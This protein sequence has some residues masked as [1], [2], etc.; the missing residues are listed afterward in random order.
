VGFA[1]RAAIGLLSLIFVS[2][3]LIAGHLIARVERRHSR[4][5][6]QAGLPS[7]DFLAC[8]MPDC[9]M[10]SCPPPSRRLIDVTTSPTAAP[11]RLADAGDPS[12]EAQAPRP[13]PLPA[14]TNA[15][16]LRPEGPEFPPTNDPPTPP[17]SAPSAPGGNSLGRRIID[18]M[19]PN[20][21]PEEREVWHDQFKDLSPS[22]VREL[23]RL[24]DMFGRL[25]RSV[26]DNREPPALLQPQPV[27]L[28]STGAPIDLP[29]DSAA[30]PAV[31]D[32]DRDSSRTIATSLE[33][34]GQAQ[35]LVIN[36]VANAGTDGY[37]RQVVSLEGASKFSATRHAQI[38][39]GVR[40]GPA[41]VDFSQGKIR[42][43]DRPLDLA[44]E[45]D[46]FFELE[47]RHTKQTY[48]T[49]SGRF[50]LNAQGELVWRTTLRELYLVPSVTIP[51]SI[52]R[53]EIEA[54]GSLRLPAD[55]D[56]PAPGEANQHGQRIQITQFPATAELVSIGE[57]LFVIRGDSPPDLARAAASDPVG[58]S[59]LVRVRQGCLEE[60]N[61]DIERELKQLECLRR[62][63]RAL[64][65]A[66]QSVP[67]SQPESLIAPNGGPGMPSHIATAPSRDRR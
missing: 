16:P 46:G 59:H 4:S 24:R 56:K 41:I 23:L 54:D 22:N 58:E 5:T 43:T 3:L 44:I 48:Y 33:A 29:I 53:I 45:G 64:E 28:P 11:V 1:K 57:N 21:S 10:P 36:N 34:I 12:L 38:G 40:L 13:L 6:A 49:R 25:P 39:V 7:D 32:A 61:V 15:I 14:R 51:G 63:A 67:F 62:Q 27:P 2:A 35:Q 26:F 17:A 19:L 37:K 31:L 52:N 50:A 20:A 9:K 65:M 18:G 30:A 47:D 8:Q 42:R 66:A 60:S 55:K